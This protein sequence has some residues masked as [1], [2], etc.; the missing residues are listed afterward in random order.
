MN[1][2]VHVVPEKPLSGDEDLAVQHSA[3]HAVY[4]C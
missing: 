4:V 2:V 1:S 3:T